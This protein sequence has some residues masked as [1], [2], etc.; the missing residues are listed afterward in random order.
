MK[1]QV[2]FHERF[3]EEYTSDPAADSGRMESIIR[4]LKNFEIIEPEPAVEED[5]LLIHTHNHLNRVKNLRNRI[6][7]LA[8]LAAGGAILAS[9]CAMFNNQPMFAAIRPPGHHASPEG[10]WGFCYFNNIAI[11]VQKLI[12]EKK[13]DKAVIIDFDLH[14]G[15]G[16]DNAFSNVSNIL[17]YSV[18]GPTGVQFIKNMTD[19]LKI[20]ED[21]DLVAVSAG[22]DRHVDDWGRL[23]T[24]EDYRTIGEY[25][26]KFSKKLCSGKRFAVLEGGYN[27]NVLGKN[28][29]A[30]LEG[31]Y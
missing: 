30:F 28:V 25:L 5:I 3:Y 2:I 16:T 4:E 26:R 12:S 20:L 10:F 19:Y 15:D 17:Y 9:E 29:R 7:P 24:T 21:I 1:N 22:F 14:F 18:R 13:I 6:Y 23:L 31:F 11:A 27:H 8:L